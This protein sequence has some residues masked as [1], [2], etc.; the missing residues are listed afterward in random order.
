MLAR[1]SALVIFQWQADC[2]SEHLCCQQDVL[3][4]CNVLR[5]VELQPRLFL[6]A[7]QASVEDQVIDPTATWP[8][9]SC[10]NYTQG[11]VVCEACHCVQA[12][13]TDGLS[14]SGYSRNVLS[15]VY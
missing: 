7:P 9:P 10:T 15:C 8:I 4:T 1:T 3:P 2:E 14:M 12:V 6:E 5:M 11:I 13:V